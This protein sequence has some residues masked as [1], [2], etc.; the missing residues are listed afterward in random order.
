MKLRRRQLLALAGTSAA[1][2]AA[3]LR[4]ARAEAKGRTA[5]PVTAQLCDCSAERRAP[6]DVPHLTA[7]TECLQHEAVGGVEHL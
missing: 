4:A 3:G 7:E 5:M 6:I 1:L 2:S